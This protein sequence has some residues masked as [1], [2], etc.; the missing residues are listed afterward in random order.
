MRISILSSNQ[1]VHLK[2]DTDLIF[3]FFIKH[4]F[5]FSFSMKPL[6][7]HQKDKAYGLC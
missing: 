3:R 2:Y 1:I 4:T 6:L 7:E 5:I